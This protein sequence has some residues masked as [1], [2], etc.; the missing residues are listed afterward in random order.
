MERGK[1]VGGLGPGPGPRP[2][3][4]RE[5]KAARRRAAQRRQEPASQR[6]GKSYTEK[7]Q[8]PTATAMLIAETRSLGVDG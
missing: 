7:D 2:L 8:G 1:R 5:Q 4:E 6:A 3:R